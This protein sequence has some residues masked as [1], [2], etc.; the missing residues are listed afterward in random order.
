MSFGTG[1]F[2]NYVTPPK[3]NTFDAGVRDAL[4][5]KKR[6]HNTSF[7]SMSAEKLNSFV[8]TE[9]LSN[10]DKQAE[11][12]RRADSYSFG[13]AHPEFYRRLRT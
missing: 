10:Q 11:A 4:D 7:D 1:R 12:I 5:G 2:G 6:T 8:K 9:A 13:I 3:D